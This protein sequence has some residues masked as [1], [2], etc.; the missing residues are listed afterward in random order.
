MA[1]HFGAVEQRED[2][3]GP[4]TQHHQRRRDR[5][6]DDHAANARVSPGAAS[7]KMI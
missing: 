7:P 5:K 1:A 4:E 3:F 2:D 6:N